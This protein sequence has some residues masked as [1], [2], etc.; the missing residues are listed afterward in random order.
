MDCLIATLQTTR[1]ASLW[2]DSLKLISQKRE[3][4]FGLPFSFTI[5]NNNYNNNKYNDA[6]NVAIVVHFQNIFRLRSFFISCFMSV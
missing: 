4:T 1:Q 5:N 2:F 3:V 6:P